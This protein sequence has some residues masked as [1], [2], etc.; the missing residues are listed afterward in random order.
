MQDGAVVV[1]P[2]RLHRRG[3][4]AVER[5]LH[6]AAVGQHRAAPGLI[7]GIVDI[8]PDHLRQ[9]HRAVADRLQ[10]LIDD[11]HLRRLNRRHSRAV[12]DQLA[13][14]AGKQAE[15][16]R[17]LAQDILLKDFGGVAIQFEHPGVECQHVLGGDIG[18]CRR[19]LAG[20]RRHVFRKGLGVADRAAAGQQYRE[21]QARVALHVTLPAKTIAH[22]SHGVAPRL[23]Y[24]AIPAL[25]KQYVL[26]ALV[27]R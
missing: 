20:D 5:R 18:G 8:G 21:R 26:H 16:H 1:T 10:Q 11:R 14:G 9:R 27:A 2:G 22:D 25:G 12:E 3:V 19:G 17:M 15:D 23:Q 4:Q 7:L 6:P 13:A 24:S